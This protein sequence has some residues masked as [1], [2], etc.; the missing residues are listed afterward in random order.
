MDQKYFFKFFFLALWISFVS[1]Q[2][3]SSQESDSISNKDEENENFEVVD[4]LSYELPIVHCTCMYEDCSCDSLISNI[5]HPYYV[6]K[7]KLELEIGTLM[8]DPIENLEPL[9]SY[10]CDEGPKVKQLMAGMR[11]L[12]EVD[13]NAFV[14][15]KELI[16]ISFST[17]KL[18]TL[19]QDL[20]KNNQKLIFLDLSHNKI[21]HLDGNLFKHTP[22]LKTLGL[23]HNLLTKFPFDNMPVL[24]ELEVLYL[25]HNPLINV[26]SKIIRKLFPKLQHIGF[27]KAQ[28][29]IEK[30]S[31]ICEA[32]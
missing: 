29:G 28:F 23:H 26:D 13:P 19:P 20:F 7:L 3:V 27:D 16:K 12:K 9:P 14:F 8:L 17:N 4:T 11:N 5:T 10:V 15:C 6:P 21:T 30:C 25:E 1:I 22:H 32:I 18:A 24:N 2:I 31:Q